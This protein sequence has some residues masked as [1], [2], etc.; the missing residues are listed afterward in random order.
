M[1]RKPVGWDQWCR[2]KQLSILLLVAVLAQ[3]ENNINC[4]QFKK[5]NSN[6][7]DTQN[8]LVQCLHLFVSRK[9][10][11]FI[12]CDVTNTTNKL[13][14]FTIEQYLRNTFNSFNNYQKLIETIQLV[15]FFHAGVT[16]NH[17]HKLSSCYLNCIWIRW[18]IVW[19]IAHA[20]AYPQITPKY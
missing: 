13:L 8:W 2:S 7:M 19:I 18:R 11:K 4:K 3:A 6:L 15:N 17:D 1:L 5:G 20:H 16:H 12:R 9:F 10:V 14:M